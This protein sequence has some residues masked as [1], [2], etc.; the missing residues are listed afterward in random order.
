MG[1]TITFKKATAAEWTS[2]NPVLASGEPG[3]ETDTTKIKIGN[4]SQA[5]DLLTYINE[6]PYAPSLS[7]VMTRTYSGTNE[8]NKL[9]MNTLG[10]VGD[11]DIISI[12]EPGD[13]SSEYD[14]G[15]G[16]G[17]NM[18]INVYDSSTG[19]I[20]RT[21]TNPEPATYSRFGWDDFKSKVFSD[22]DYIAVGAMS[23]S[24]QKTGPRKA[25]IFQLSTGS[26]V[27]SFTGSG[28]AS[29]EPFFPH[30]LLFNYINNNYLVTAEPRSNNYQ[31]RI[32]IRK[33]V[34]GDWTDTTYIGN[35]TGTGPSLGTGFFNGASA[36]E[37]FG[38]S[39]GMFGNL[40]VIGAAY[41]TDSGTGYN[42]GR[43]YI[44][45]M[46]TATILDTI[47]NPD[48]GPNRNEG[49]GQSVT[50]INANTVAVGAY[51]D[52]DVEG[53]DTNDGR[54]YIFRSE[55]GNWD[56]TTLTAT[57]NN[58]ST[59][60]G[61]AGDRFGSLMTSDGNYLLIGAERE[62][63]PGGERRG[64]GYLYT[65]SSGNW[66][67]V[68]LSYTYL[69]PRENSAYD[70]EERL[71]ELAINVNSNR[72]LFSHPNTYVSGSVGNVGTVH[73]FSLLN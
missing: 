22:A 65:T 70:A 6:E 11:K 49:F 14:A 16:V 3:I 33:S 21:I 48:P 57:L 4:G 51:F 38:K 28:E 59:N 50:M 5:W 60:N 35:V 23:I 27:H 69:N 29:T 68:T 47:E 61:T 8:H 32:Q 12:R 73:Q 25:W 45:D 31:G 52:E 9:G 72:M 58:P 18:T 17:R 40:A 30:N 41:S 64:A 1:T 39:V 37:A 66:S 46:D 63:N 13:P 19:V 44:V 71:L 7:P 36:N 10:I 55:S 62:E 43:A 20:E 53:S 54:A 24:N 34:S 56:D 42:I 15:T 26:I 67:D 2:S